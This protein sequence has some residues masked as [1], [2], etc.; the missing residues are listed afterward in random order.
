MRETLYCPCFADKKTVAYRECNLP[1]D[2]RL[3]EA[4]LKLGCLSPEVTYF[5]HRVEA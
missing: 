1:K 4:D 2:N 5:N 3:V